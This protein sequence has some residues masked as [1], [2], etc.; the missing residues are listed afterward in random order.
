M[1]NNFKPSPQQQAIFDELSN[2]DCGSIIIEAKAGSGKTTTIVEA[3]K[4]IG[5]SIFLGAFNKKMADEL[6]SRCANIR[7][8]E[9]ATFHAIGYR[10]LR[11]AWDNVGKTDSS[12]IFNLIKF[13]NSQTYQNED[14]DKNAYQISRIISMAKQRGIGVLVENDYYNWNEMIL[15]HSLDE[16]LPTKFDDYDNMKNLIQFC[17]DVLKYDIQHSTS[18]DFDDMIYLPLLHNV[19]LPTFDWVMIDEAQDTNNV[20]REFAK[21]MINEN[22]RIIA[23]GD[24]HQSI[25]GFAGA[26][27]DSMDKIQEDFNAKVMPLSVSYRCSKAVINL[28]NN[29]VYDIHPCQNA[30]DGETLCINYDDIV[31]HA[32]N[33]DVIISRFNKY[34]VNICFKFLRKGIAVKIEGRDIAKNL[35]SLA[36]MWKTQ[37]FNELKDLVNKWKHRE[38]DRAIKKGVNR[39][40]TITDRAESLMIMVA[41]AKEI[42]LSSKD[43]MIEMIES[44]FADN[45]NSKNMIT[46]CS[47]HKAKGMEWDRVFLIGRNE[48]MGKMGYLQWQKDQ[49]KNLIYVGITRARDTLIDVVNIPTS[50]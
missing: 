39:T 4:I 45:I 13:F 11:D 31:N 40:D 24:R 10:A 37:D 49:E 42:G 26:D 43:E 35:T 12:K 18:I 23:V 9:C 14:F 6:S 28:A 44:L 3:S 29:Y 1:N 16:Q 34:L 33:G 20:R 25:Y 50:V 47:V 21:R 19:K 8:A 30:K 2:P 46:L 48:I 7:N 38:I 27:N 41:R 17:R 22:G 5:G 36:K 15:H 32:K